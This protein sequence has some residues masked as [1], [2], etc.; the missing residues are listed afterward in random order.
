MDVA[1][2]GGHIGQVPTPSRREH[3]GGSREQNGR[4][5]NWEKKGAALEVA[6]VLMFSLLMY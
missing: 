4:K 1:A 3:V 6:W 5:E 2:T